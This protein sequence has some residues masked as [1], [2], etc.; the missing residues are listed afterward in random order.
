[1]QFA[2]T[3]LLGRCFLGLV[4]PGLVSLAPLGVVSAQEPSVPEKSSIVET[5]VSA[6]KFNTLA[7][8]LKAADLI[9]ALS[10]EGPF[11]VFAPTD[12]A[13]AALPEGTVDE[14]LKPEN[15]DR[16]K[17]ILLY[18]VA[19][20][21]TK[22][23]EAVKLD[24]VQTL[25][26]Q[27][28]AIS[29]SDAALKLNEAKVIASDIEC[30]NGVIHVID[31]VLL[32]LTKTIPQV[33]DEAGVFKTLLAAVGQAGLAEALSGEGPFTVFA[34][35]DEA[36]SR[37][38]QGTVES[39]LKPE[40]KGKLVEIL[41]YHVVAKKLD[42]GD[43]LA[44]KSLETLSGKNITIQVSDRGPLVND[45]LIVQVDI[46]ASNGVIHVIDRVLIPSDAKA[47]AMKKIEETVARGAELYNS[48]HHHACATLYR[49]ALQEMMRTEV[50]AT[51]GEHMRTT[52][53]NADRHHTASGKAW[54]LRRG[55]DQMYGLM[56][57]SK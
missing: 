43:V 17:S 22:G 34:P 12:E 21:S 28:I 13:F 47:V 20:G 54:A 52:I 19:S 5:A 3:R 15:K 55:I 51:Y 41:K 7:A 24:K 30:S 35:T 39:L 25:N 45:S 40:N 9:D 10:G 42:S 4:F 32:P 11:T 56:L 6:G 27:S 49:N 2:V 26:G 14:L 53:H 33:A 29:F 46:E 50:G 38:P 37:L 48:G 8:A 18:H 1:M 31:S 16:L 36:F 44:S 23:A 57:K